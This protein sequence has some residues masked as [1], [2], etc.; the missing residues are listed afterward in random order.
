MIGG[1]AFAGERLDR[2]AEFLFSLPIARTKLLASKLLLALGIAAAP[3]LVNFLILCC[4]GREP[5]SGFMEPGDERVYGAFTDTAITVMA[6]FG[7]AWFVSSFIGSPAY[8]A[9][10]G[11]LAPLIVL[12]AIESAPVLLDLRIPLESERWYRGIC[13]LLGPLCFALGT[14]HYLRRVEP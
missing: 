7:V 6:I 8:A 9:C 12:L 4:V 11:L 1:N 10:L 2:S 13:L 3:W 14:G 5:P